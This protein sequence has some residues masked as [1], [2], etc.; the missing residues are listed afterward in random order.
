[1]NLSEMVDQGG[2]IEEAAELALQGA[3]HVASLGGRAWSLLLEGE[4]ATRMISLGRLDEA[5]H[6][7]ETAL[8]LPSSLGALIQCSARAQ[9]EVQRGRGNEAQ[10]LI[11]AAEEVMPHV[12]GT[13]WP[14]PLA[15][16]RSELELLR[17][18]PDEAWRLGEQALA[19]T[20]DGEYVA[21]TA[22]VHAVMAR[23]GAL[24]AERSRAAGNEPAATETAAR[25]RAL[26][27]R[28]D[29]ML[30][31]EHWRGAPPAE[32]VAFRE[33]A[34]AEARRAA[35]TGASSDW[36]AV[37]DR[38][39]Q[40]QMPIERAYA[41]LRQ[42]ESHVLAGERKEADEV[43]GLGLT[44]TKDCGASW[45]HDQLSV[46]ARRARLS[47]PGD[48]SPERAAAADPV[49]ALGLTERELSVLELVARG[50]TNREIGEH[51]FMAEKTASVHVSRILAKLDVG[52]RVEAATAAQR[53][54]I[55]R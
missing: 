32:T 18:D 54:G 11:R 25:T 28:I 26:V 9:I 10:Q 33:L 24:L 21:F 27:D 34:A 52:S 1:M 19:T 30:G 39:S 15:S 48:P 50:L 3:A 20:A 44:I 17:G 16:T 35:G 8:E 40:L 2:R 7:T 37:A 47:V 51:L 36:A 46:L 55:V 23:A 29:R 6:L 4:A 31:P 41:L 14:E 22:R 12:P 43:T 53:L 5:D 13:T 42:A 45:L 49:E 38:W